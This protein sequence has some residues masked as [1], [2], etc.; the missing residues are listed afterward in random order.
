MPMEEDHTG[1][2]QES[3]SQICSILVV[4]CDRQTAARHLGCSVRDILAEAERDYQF[5]KE[6]HRA[7]ASHELVHMKNIFAAAKS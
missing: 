5:A 1:L 3:K 6:I 7:E 2:S 4:G